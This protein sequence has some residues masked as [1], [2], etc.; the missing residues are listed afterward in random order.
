MIFF[1]ELLL[2][3]WQY[4]QQCPSLHVMNLTFYDDLL[5]ITLPAII[6][7][8]VGSYSQPQMSCQSIFIFGIFNSNFMR[9]IFYI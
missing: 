5:V 9:F 7:F 8:H 4:L 1:V 3:V 6:T 2:Y